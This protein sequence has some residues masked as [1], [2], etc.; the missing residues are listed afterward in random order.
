M[1]WVHATMSQVYVGCTETFCDHIN[2]K[3]QEVEC[4]SKISPQMHVLPSIGCNHF[5]K[6]DLQC[7]FAVH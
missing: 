6:Q 5:L 7:Y 1:V 4:I 2:R 3:V